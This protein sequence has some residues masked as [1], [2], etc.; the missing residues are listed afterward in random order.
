METYNRCNH[1]YWSC[2]YQ[3][4]SSPKRT[5]ISFLSHFSS[6]NSIAPQATHQTGGHRNT[7]GTGMSRWDPNPA[8]LLPNINYTIPEGSLSGRVEGPGTPA[9]PQQDGGS[10]YKA[11]VCPHATPVSQTPYLS[12]LLLLREPPQFSLG[13]QGI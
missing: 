1:P 13:P 7:D 4:F 5:A 10:D 11:R 12:D 6:L 8:S 9:S 2:H 3:V